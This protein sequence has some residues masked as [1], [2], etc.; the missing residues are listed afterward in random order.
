MKAIPP[1]RPE[2]RGQDIDEKPGGVMDFRALV[3]EAAFIQVSVRA[4]IS[5]ELSEM[6]SRIKEDFS[7]LLV[8]ETE[9]VL[10]QAKDKEQGPGLSSTFPERSRRILSRRCPAE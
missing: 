3:E 9:R 4:R 2:K 6:S 10:K 5:K 7:H 8:E 1:P